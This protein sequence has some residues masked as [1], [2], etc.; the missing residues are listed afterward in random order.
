MWLRNWRGQAGRPGRRHGALPSAGLPLSGPKA[1][2]RRQRS[3]FTL[4]ELLVVAAVISLLLI[5]LLPSLGRARDL[6]KAAMCRSNLKQLWEVFH[7]NTSENALRFPLPMAWVEFVTNQGVE[8]ITRCPSDKEVRCSD[9]ELSEVYLVQDPGGLTFYPILEIINKGPM[10]LFQCE[11]FDRGGGTYEI[12][13]GNY[14]TTSVLAESDADAAVQVIL[15]S[16]A[17][18]QILD[19]PG[20]GGP[21]DWIGCGSDHWLCHGPNIGLAN[22]RD[23]IKRQ[24][25]GMSKHDV[26]E[27]YYVTGMPCSYGMNTYV[28]PVN[29]PPGQ[30]LLLDYEKQVADPV[31]DTIDDEL[32]FLA[33]RHLGRVNAVFV[34]GAVRNLWPWELDAGEPLWQP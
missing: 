14:E 15:G 23:D 6:S 16:T 31:M 4:V 34:S 8:P 20:D 17:V 18:I 21:G 27:P 28:A 25:T 9:L 12:W 13:I 3:G 32:R 7:S 10:G 29:A 2:G 22:W 26:E 5:M 19:P 30:L 24:L 33:P 11:F 1:A